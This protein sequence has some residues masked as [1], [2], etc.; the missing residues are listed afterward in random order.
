MGGSLVSEAPREHNTRSEQSRRPVSRLE[1]QR[2]DPS[3]VCLA[4]CSGT[5]LHP[6]SLN[7]FL[8][9]FFFFKKSYMFNLIV[10]NFFF[11]LEWSVIKVF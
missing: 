11:F 3:S 8:K 7:L 1:A 6:L 10:L 9:N 2:S 4:V 5:G